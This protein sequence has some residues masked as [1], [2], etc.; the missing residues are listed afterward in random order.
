MS[1]QANTRPGVNG[2]TTVSAPGGATSIQR[3]SGP[4]R[5]SRRFSKPSFST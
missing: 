1:S 3:A 4:M 2:T 5:S